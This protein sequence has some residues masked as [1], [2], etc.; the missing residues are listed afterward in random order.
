MVH[1]IV[2]T[3][4]AHLQLAEKPSEQNAGAVNDIHRDVVN[5][6][7]SQINDI[8][9]TNVENRVPAFKSRSPTDGE[10]RSPFIKSPDIGFSKNSNLSSGGKSESV[11]QKCKFR[12]LRKHGDLCRNRPQDSK[13]QTNGP[14]RNFAS[15]WAGADDGQNHHG[16]GNYFQL[17]PMY[18]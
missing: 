2:S 15:S 10:S 12:R 1:D 17:V 7:S 8:P 3:P 4:G 18:F 6:I 5:V 14:S 13:E 9:A 16:R 11:K